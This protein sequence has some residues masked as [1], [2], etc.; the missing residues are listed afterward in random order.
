[1]LDEL[2]AKIWIRYSCQLQGLIAEQQQYPE[3][4]HSTDA[5]PDETAV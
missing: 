3:L 2:R 1:M 5:G 4:D